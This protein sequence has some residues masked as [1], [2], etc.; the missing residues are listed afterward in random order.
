MEKKG[1]HQD[2]DDYVDDVDQVDEV[3]DDG[4]CDC[5]CDYYYYGETVD[6]ENDNVDKVVNIIED[7]IEIQVDNHLFIF[8]QE[9]NGRASLPNWI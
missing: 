5:D 9:L 2:Y 7:I 3:V 4:D 6:D 8:R 1:N